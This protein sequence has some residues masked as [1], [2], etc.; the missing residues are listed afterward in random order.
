MGLGQT[1]LA[2]NDALVLI[3]SHTIDHGVQFSYF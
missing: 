3:S 1:F 2:L